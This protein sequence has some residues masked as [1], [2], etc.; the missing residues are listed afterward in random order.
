MR[1]FN[2][3]AMNAFNS[4]KASSQQRKVKYVENQLSIPIV[5]SIPVPNQG[6]NGDLV[7]FSSPLKN[8]SVL[9][10]KSK[11]KWNT[12]QTSGFSNYN[13][14][15]TATAAMATST[16]H[17]TG[18]F[19]VNNS[20]DTNNLSNGIYT[21]SHGKNSSL[22][23][24][25]VF[26]RFEALSN[27]MPQLYTIDLSSH[28]SN[29]GPN[30]N[31][32]GYWVNIVDN[33]TIE[34]HIHPDGL[35]ILHSEI[36]SDTNSNTSTLLSSLDSSNIGLLEL[37]VVVNPITGD[38]NM[39]I[40]N[41][42]TD[43]NNPYKSNSKTSRVS[44]SNTVINTAGAKEHGTK[45]SN[46][47]I[48]IG[49]TGVLLK[50][51]NGTLQVRNEDDDA[52]A[53]IKAKRLSLPTNLS[54]TGDAIKGQ[55]HYDSSD[56]AYKLHGQYLMLDSVT[57]GT[58]G[59]KAGLLI[60]PSYED[61]FVKFFDQV[62]AKWTIGY[63]GYNTTTFTDA[64][65]VL[66]ADSTTVSYTNGSA[67]DLNGAGGLTVSG[68]GIPDNTYINSINT[69]AN[70]F[71]MTNAATSGDGSATT[72]LTFNT[73]EN[74][75]K[76]NA[77]G[78]LDDASTFELDNSGNLEIEGTLDVKGASVNV[79]ASSLMTISE[80][81]IDVSS[82]DLTLDVG[83]DIKLD[84]GGN[85]IYLKSSGTTAAA[86]NTSTNPHCR[87]YGGG[88]I[89]SADYLQLRVTGA[90]GAGTLQ[91]HDAAGSAAHLTIDAD[92]DLIMTSDTGN[93]IAQKAGTEFSV[94]NS[95]YAGMII[96][97]SS[98]FNTTATAGYNTITISTTMAVLTTAN[99]NLVNIVF[100]A[101]PSGN[102]EIEL[103]CMVY[104]SSKEI[105]FSLS[106]AAI[107]NEVD[108]IHTYDDVGYKTDETDYDI[109]DTKFVVTGLT[110]GNS[111]QYWLA[112]KSSS[113]SSYIYHGK[114][115]VGTHTHPIIVKAV[116]LPG[117]ITTGT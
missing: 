72:T 13:S 32:Y 115:R 67:V 106:D 98:Y 114:S 63:D 75:F 4:R 96:G 18:W 77:G 20:D 35:S 58:N 107:Y 80:N 57:T 11:G 27:G 36:L 83:G 55:I 88:N 14:N 74:K 95:A 25:N 65:C 97:Y 103:S 101:P 47:K 8:E 54:G 42:K 33:N 113:N 99:S 39:P 29:S 19:Q 50:N 70:T 93:F 84:T 12:V 30:A 7:I 87:L 10:Y 43:K 49:S 21:I 34:V 102:V 24:T 38:R 94:A 61:S 76:I 105:M 51:N 56:S 2:K 3:K 37:R 90:S 28:V 53:V 44:S 9:Y 100:T 46:F 85:D 52:D 89:S 104:G 66:T 64:T 16:I 109:V 91:T 68:T 40:A 23:T 92:G 26:C 31:R 108:Q 48:G 116:A 6:N 60:L 41:N 15:N 73:I 111:Y 17:D 79:G 45:E 81:E 62:S 1:D 82:G 112:A 71:L 86:I 59:E 22:V 117:T 110:A 78:T 5:T 69:G